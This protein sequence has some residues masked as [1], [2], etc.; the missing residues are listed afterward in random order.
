[1]T[2]PTTRTL[3]KDDWMT[4]ALLF[5][6]LHALVCFDFDACATDAEVA[7]LPVFI[8]PEQDALKVRW[9]DFGKRGFVN[10]PYGRTIHR[11]FAKAAAACAEG[12]DTVV[13]L[14]YANTDTKYWRQHVVENPLTQLVIFL[15]PRLH[16]VRPDGVSAGGAPKG[17]ALVI[18][19]STPRKTATIPHTYW[20]YK[21]QPLA[22]VLSTL[23]PEQHH[24]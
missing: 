20:S 21:T 3:G 8:S 7:Q 16:F 22:D 19:S 4:E 11:W 6:P 1:M 9:A 13:L 5:D 15:T 14:T 12:C 10:P 24:D 23:I 2:N 17:S 18:Y